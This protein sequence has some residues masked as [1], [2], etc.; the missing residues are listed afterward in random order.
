MYQQESDISENIQELFN[1]GLESFKKGN[2]DYAIELF[3]QFLD[4]MPDHI[5]ARHYLRLAER[6]RFKQTPPPALASFFQKLLSQL[7]ILK[8]SIL[9]SKGRLEE[10][11]REYEKALRRDPNNE[12]AL[13][14]LA[15]CLMALNMDE[16]AIDTFEEIRAVNPNNAGALKKLADLYLKHENYTK[17]QECFDEILKLSPHDIETERGLKNLAALGTIKKGGWEKETSSYEKILDKTQSRQLEKEQHTV[18]TQGDINFL[19][20]QAKKSEK[21][22]SSLKKLAELQIKANQLKEA[23]ETCEEIKNKHPFDKETLAKI[24]SLKLQIIDQKILTKENLIKNKPAEDTKKSLEEIKALK[25]E[26]SDSRLKNLQEQILSFPNDLTLRYEY[27][28]ALYEASN[29]DE[30]ISQLQL[31]VKEPTQKSKSLNLL[32]M[33]FK[34]K[35]MLDLASMQFKKAHESLPENSRRSQEAK[36]IIYNLAQTYEEIGKKEAAL[37][38]YK[39]IY[40]F[41]IS[42]KDVA[43]KVEQSYDGGVKT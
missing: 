16:I 3:E 4:L 37:E 7:I 31:A 30:A 29:I 34:Y 12:S 6:G 11:I 5:K 25:K 21:S 23:L 28:Q 15:V 8:A 41:D 9:N 42:Y 38:E 20:E 19:L 10:T 32:G 39:K 18:K 43:K 36:E 26:R 22:L 2:F 24:L 40:E 17:A 33:A 27:G 14:K 35:K 1:K 13:K